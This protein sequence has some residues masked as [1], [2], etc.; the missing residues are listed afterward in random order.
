MLVVG[1]VRYLDAF[2]G[3]V[4]AVLSC[5]LLREVSNLA[6]RQRGRARSTNLSSEYPDIVGAFCLCLAHI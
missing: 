3:D 4:G 6:G 5:R 2:F 1:F